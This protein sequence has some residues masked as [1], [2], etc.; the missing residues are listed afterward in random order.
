MIEK[1]INLNPVEERHPL[2]QGLKPITAV[3]L[4]CPSPVEERHPLKQGLKPT[5]RITIRYIGYSLKR[6]IH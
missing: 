1:G 5:I 2:K 4:K 3:N 6:D